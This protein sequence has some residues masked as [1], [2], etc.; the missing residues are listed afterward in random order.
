[1]SSKIMNAISAYYEN[2]SKITARVNQVYFGI[3]RIVASGSKAPINQN[4]YNNIMKK[5]RKYYEKRKYSK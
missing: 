1:M 3:S 5:E 2:V 4:K